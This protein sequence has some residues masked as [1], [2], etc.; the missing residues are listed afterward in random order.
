MKDIKVGQIDPKK[1]STEPKAKAN[2]QLRPYYAPTDKKFVQYLF[3]STYFNLV[4]RAVRLRLKSP[5]LLAVW[6][7]IY[8]SLLTTV[9]S[10]ASKLG[11]SSHLELGVQIVITIVVLGGGIIALLWY[12]D[13]F[14][15]TE[16]VLQGI[17]ND[18][19]EPDVYYRGTPQDPRNGNF[20]VMTLNDDIVGCIGIDHTPVTV[21]DKSASA[22]PYVRASERPRAIDAPEIHQAKWKKTALILA[23]IDDFVRLTLVGVLD[24]A[25]D[26]YFKLTGAPVVKEKVLFEAHKPN[27]ASIRR[28]AVKL[29]CQNHGLSTVLLKRAAFWA[30]AHQVEYLYADVDE[31]QEK[32]FVDILTKKHGYVFVSKKKLGY[33]KTKST[34]R[35]DVKLWMSQ[36]LERRKQEHILEEQAKEDEELKQYE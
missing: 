9:P 7:G 33:Y 13:K 3:Y 18:L 6:I 31:L 15:I 23:K 34:Y 20:W 2:I 27:E 4:P 29:E 10:Y 1:T 26:V 17:E 36:E 30:H 14:D 16:R 32:K 21:M 28:L 35:L 12:T 25:R 24:V 5:L 19:K 11:W 8:A 22:K